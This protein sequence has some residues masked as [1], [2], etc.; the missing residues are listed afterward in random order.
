[1]KMEHIQSRWV[2][3]SLYNLIVRTAR[4]SG[5]RWDGS[6]WRFLQNRTKSWNAP[7]R[8]VIHDRRVIVNFGYTYP[9]TARLYPTFNNPLIELVHQT[10]SCLRRRVRVADVGAA[11][12]DTV[13]LIEA[14]CPGEV[15][16]Y[17]CLDG[18]REFFNYLQHNLAHLNNCRLIFRQL[19]R[20]QSQERALV[21]THRGTASAQGTATVLTESL[22][23]LAERGELGTID[24]L[25]IDVDGFDGE[26]IM[27]ARKTLASQRPS[28]IFE[29]HPILCQQT[30]NNIRDHFVGL[31]EAG[32]RDLV[33]FTKFGDFSHFGQLGEDDAIDKL[34]E[35]CLRS[36]TLADWHYDVI[37]LHEHSPV[38]PVSLADLAFA[39]NRKSRY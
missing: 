37:A 21:R 10:S 23:E 3:S 31:E 19:S 34:S 6:L 2:E 4:R 28:V 9:I 36:T 11:V 8:T 13:L 33:W 24:I 17:V 15:E 25:K 5:R 30:G 32:Y 26:V 22:D 12:G 1:M 35:L 39:R 16:Q 20:E 7:V 27:G 18:D 29:W 14:N 38:N